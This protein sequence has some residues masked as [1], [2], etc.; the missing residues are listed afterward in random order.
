M[1]ALEILTEILGYGEIVKQY[2]LPIRK[3]DNNFWSWC[4]IV[5][6]EESHETH[7]MRFTSNTTS[8]KQMFIVSY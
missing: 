1:Q 6:R 3:F 4:R 5:G 8:R 2:F 7:I